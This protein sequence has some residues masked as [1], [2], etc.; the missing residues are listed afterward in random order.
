MNGDGFLLDLILIS[1]SVFVI[2]THEFWFPNI[3][4]FNA[5]TLALVSLNVKYIF[6]MPF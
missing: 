3:S 2:G 6:E 1:T 4:T 5:F